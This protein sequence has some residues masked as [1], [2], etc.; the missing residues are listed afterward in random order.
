MK[1]EKI[2]INNNGVKVDFYP[3]FTTSFVETKR[4]NFLNVSLKHKIVQSKTILEY[5]I[6]NDYKKKDK[7]EEIREHLKKCVFKDSYKGKNYKI[8]DIDFDR[9]PENTSFTNR[10]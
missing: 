7:K 2:T 9:K 10:Q 1:E 3:G 6:E 8:T 5:L 4:G